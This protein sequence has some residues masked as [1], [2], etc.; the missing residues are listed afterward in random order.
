MK[1]KFNKKA[2]TIVAICLCLLVCGTIGTWAYLTSIT[3][4]L[5]NTFV[6][7]KVT[8]TV[9]ESF[10]DGVKSDVKV[11]NTGDVDAYVRV[12][13]VATFISDNNVYA[14][15]PIEGVDYSVE[16]SNNKWKKGTD[17]FWYYSDP[18][19]PNAVTNNLI[20]KATSS[21]VPQ[22]Y[23]L[24]IQIIA[25]AIQSDPAAAVQ[26]AWGIT[27]VNGKINPN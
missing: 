19:S 26:S 11:R 10:E 24:N 5:Q 1:T 21:S 15:S 17:G 7:A 23:N 2:V 9:E 27:P 8:C 3:D 12:A 13:V 18:V 14:V 16:W 6:P 20:E 4:P 22:G 25:T